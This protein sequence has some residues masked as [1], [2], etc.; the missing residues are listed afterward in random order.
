[1]EFINIWVI[2]QKYIDNFT[3]NQ[4]KTEVNKLKYKLIKHLKYKTKTSLTKMDYKIISFL[5]RGKRRK[6]VLSSLTKPK[7]PKQIAE[8]CKLSPSNVGVALSEL[9]KKD[10]IRCLTPND[11][12]FKFYE[13]SKKGKIALNNFIEYEKE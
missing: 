12:I 3:I 6:K 5:I 4:F 9:I 2:H 10:L 1:M 11:K 13:I 8:E 7:M